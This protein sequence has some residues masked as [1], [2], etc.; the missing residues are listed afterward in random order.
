MKRSQITMRQII[1]VVLIHIFFFPFLLHSQNTSTK[2]NIILVMADDLGY[3]SLSCDGGQSYQT[4]NLDKLATTGIRFDQCFSQPLCT[5]SRVQIMTG[6]YNF[7][8]YKMFG[9]Y[10]IEE[11]SFGNILKKAG[12][13]TCIA[14]KWQLSNGVEGPHLAG[15]DEYCLWQIYRKIAGEWVVGSRYADPTIHINGQLLKD[16]EGKY[17]P[18][19]F[20]DFIVNFIEQK[21]SEPFFVYYPMV[22]THDPFSPSPDHPDWK[23]DKFAKDTTYFADM[24]SYMDKIVGRIVDKLDELK[25]RDNTL[26]LFTGDNGTHS[27]IYSKLNGRL[28]RGGKSRMIA[29]G[30][31]VPF[32]AN[33]AG[34]ISPNQVSNNLIDFSD[35][36]PTLADLAEAEIPED[37]VID[38]KSFFAQLMGERGTPRDWVYMYYWGRGRNLLEKK[39]SAQTS[40]LKLYDN[41]EFYDFITDPLEKKP[42]ADHELTEEQVMV[43]TRLQDVLDNIKNK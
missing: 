7:R 38:G 23:V 32:I 29:A 34:T 5:P 12:Y 13:Q 31:H 16:T 19:I 18:D 15:F 3:E 24:V 36:F 30:T 25:I 28:I 6:R 22:L 42:I 26:I 4:P 1:E 11:V 40:Q 41:G 14:G 10:S 35:F 17:G 9:Y 8:N 2:P 27:S 37:L 39:E 21:K 20:C 33:W 43:R